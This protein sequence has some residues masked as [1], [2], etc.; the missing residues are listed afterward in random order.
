MLKTK[1]HC[2]LF[3]LPAKG[4]IVSFLIPAKYTFLSLIISL[5]HSQSHLSLLVF[6]PPPLYTH[7]P[8]LES[9]A[10][11]VF[12]SLILPTVVC[13]RHLKDKEKNCNPKNTAV[14]PPSPY[15]SLSFSLSLAMSTRSIT[16]SSFFLCVCILRSK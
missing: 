10:V 15:L 3:L 8:I 5:S 1:L 12:S 13:R 14:P 4:T 7:T 2:S 11:P 16:I 9:G 6:L